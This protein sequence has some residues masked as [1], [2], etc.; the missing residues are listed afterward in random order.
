MLDSTVLRSLRWRES[1]LPVRCQIGCRSR[2][3]IVPRYRCGPHR[4]MDMVVSSVQA[5]FVMDSA[6]ASQS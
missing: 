5:D 1:G 2:S 3:T 4:C 6:I